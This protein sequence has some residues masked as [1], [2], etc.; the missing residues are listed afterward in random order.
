VDFSW[1]LGKNTNNKEETLVVYMGL[2]IAHSRNIQAL[3]VIGDSEIVIRELLGIS[4]SATQPSSGLHTR[5]KS[6]KQLFP[7][8]H[9]FHILRSQN[10]EVDRLA[11]STKSIEQGQ[12]FINQISSHAWLP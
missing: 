1:G 12:L 9:F 4:T 8:I 10:K 2:Q 6:L 3:T 11:K 7:K 5:I